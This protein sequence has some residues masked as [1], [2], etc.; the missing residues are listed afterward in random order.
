[1]CAP[2][3]PR[4]GRDRPRSPHTQPSA[5]PG[6]TAVLL[7]VSPAA[8]PWPRSLRGS[9]SRRRG[10]RRGSGRLPAGLALGSARPRSRQPPPTSK[11]NN[12]RG[13]STPA[14]SPEP[15]VREKITALVEAG[16]LG[17]AF[18]P[19]GE[20]AQGARRE[21]SW[22]RRLE[23]RRSSRERPCSPSACGRTP[24]SAGASR[25]A[26]LPAPSQQPRR[27]VGWSSASA[28]PAPVMVA[29]SEHLRGGDQPLLHRVCVSP[30]PR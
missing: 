7:A 8:P 10:G 11:P 12:P 1:V 20:S 29:N 25:A 24:L 28:T 21:A 9:G 14:A 27:A 23:Q 18:R 16:E 2:Q 17:L 6:R 3:A 5:P 19:A 4:S 22:L 30:K 15:D 26:P 13:K